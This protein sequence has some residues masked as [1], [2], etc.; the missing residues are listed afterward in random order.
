[1]RI[2][3]TYI[4]INIYRWYFGS[5]SRLEGERQLFEEGNRCGSYLIRHSQSILDGYTL[6]VRYKDNV[7]HYKI[8]QKE[9]EFFIT[10][11]TVFK[12]IADLVD[13]Y[14]LQSDGLCT[15]LVRPCISSQ[16][17]Q[18]AGLSKLTNEE[19]EIDRNKIKL[20]RKLGDGRF[21]E[22]SE[23]VW[24]DTTPIAVKVFDHRVVH[25]SKFLR[26]VARMRELRHPKIVQLY[27]VCTNEQP[28]YVITEL[29][30]H[31]SLL[32]YLRNEHRSLKLSQ[33]ISMA[34]QVV[35]GMAYL[36]EHQ[37]IHRDLAARNVLVGDG[38]ICKISNFG[39]MQLVAEAE[40]KAHDGTKFAIKWTAPEALLHNSFSV[41]SDVWSFGILLYEVITYGC[42]PY[43]GMANE[44]V[45]RKLEQ[46]YRMPQP[47]ESSYAYY[48]IMLKCWRDEPENRPSFEALQWELEEFLESTR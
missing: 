1:M 41:K 24:N 30:K 46:G 31:G 12:S 32:E 11:Q 17:P 29:V 22:V 18:T 38:L 26:E 14:Q 37:Y 15:N 28:I 27:A 25:V 3:H 44:E 16:K 7:K 5:V 43:A 4:P 9:K 21:A 35:E 40:N 33:L 6:S 13:H 48:N 47:K 8:S 34:Q 23:G 19:W 39:L 45:M 10:K 2:Y 20:V 42:L 36:E